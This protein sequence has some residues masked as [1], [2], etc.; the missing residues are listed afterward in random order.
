[1]DEHSD[2]SK[3]RYHRF[4]YGQ[5][6]VTNPREF[7]H[8]MELPSG[9]FR[10]GS[11]AYCG[12]P[13]GTGHRVAR[14]GV[15][16]ALASVDFLHQMHDSTMTWDSDGHC[17]RSGSCRAGRHRC[18]FVPRRRAGGRGNAGQAEGVSSPEKVANSR[19]LNIRA[20]RFGHGS[21]INPGLRY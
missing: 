21:C 4:T 1:M 15:A 18:G 20:Y 14:P 7:S 2:E 10:C 16:A 5:V 19:L 9:R 12:R 13:D 3:E 17:A 8:L 11:A 6:S